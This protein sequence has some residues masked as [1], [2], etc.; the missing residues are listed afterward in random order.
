M[1]MHKK[2]MCD[3]YSGL[4]ILIQDVISHPD[5]KSYDKSNKLM[6]P[7]AFGPRNCEIDPLR[8]RLIMPKI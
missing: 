4:S 8:P 6:L 1:L 2:N 3:P 5:A 7:Q